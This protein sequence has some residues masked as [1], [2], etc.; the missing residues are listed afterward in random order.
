MWLF[1]GLLLGIGLVLLAIWS[2]SRKI[3]IHWYVWVLLILGL[4]LLL[5]AIQNYFASITAH[6][7]VAPYMFMLVF[8][9]PGLL[10][11][12]IAA[13]VVCFQQFMRRKSKTPA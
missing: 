11:L 12:V 2:N 10:L 7:P 5:F 1:I 9:L 4:A 8:G 3:L 6:E 13:A